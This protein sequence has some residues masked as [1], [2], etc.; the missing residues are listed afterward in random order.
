M[1]QHSDTQVNFLSSVVSS[2]LLL[3]AFLM[4]GCS[5]PIVSATNPI[6]AGPHA[7]LALGDS[8]TIGEAVDEEARWPVQLVKALRQI[9]VTIDDPTIL[10]RTGWTTENLQN[11]LNAASY[12]GPY[13]LVS[14]MIGVND[15][16]RRQSPEDYRPRFAKLLQQA[17]ALA[18]G[19]AGHVLVVSIPDY[20]YGPERK[21]A[22]PKIGETID[23][24]NVVCKEEAQRL[25][26]VYVDVTALSRQDKENESLRANDNLHF[27]GAMYALWVEAM[28]P[29][30]MKM[31]K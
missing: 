6:K 31:L 5:K 23:L 28:L 17:I 12:V 1:H 2:S 19:K 27:S 10:A 16:Y 13:Q 9:G 20:D 25:G 11:A 22:P 14:L 8:Y 26:A 18:G 3:V 24:F 15:Q 29:R 30:V 21:F 4:A 7:F